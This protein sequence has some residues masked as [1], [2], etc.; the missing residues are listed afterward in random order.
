MAKKKF[1]GNSGMVQ[2]HSFASRLG[3]LIVTLIVIFLAIVAVLPMW[4]V[5]MSSVSDGHTLLSYKGF[6][7]I[8]IGKFTLNAYK[9]VLNNAS[10]IQGYM[11]TIIYV[12]GAVGLGLVLNVLGGYVLYR[13]TKLNTFLSLFVMFTM[14]FGGGMVATFMVM[15][16]LHLTGTRLV[17]ILQLA[18]NAMYIVVASNAFSGVPKETV[19][20]AILDGAGDLTIMFKVMLPQCM[21]LMSVTILNTF[22]GAWNSWVEASMP[23]YKK[24]MEEHPDAAQYMT[25]DVDG[26]KKFLAI[27][28]TFED[29]SMYDQWY[30]YAY[31]RDWLVKY[32]TQPDTFYDPMVDTEPKT[33][34]NAGQAFSGHYTLDTDG[35]T[36]DTTEYSD[37]VNGDS[38]VDDVVFPSGNVDPVY[39]T[40]WEWM[41]DIFAKALEAEG[42]T[43]G[44]GLSLYYPGY[45]GTGD[46]VSGFGGIGP[47]WYLDENGKCTFGAT[48]DGFKSYLECMSTW[49]KNGWIDQRFDQRSSDAFYQ[50]DN[51]TVRQGKV[52]AWLATPSELMSRIQTD[53]LETTKGAVVYTC[54]SPINDKYGSEETQLKKPTCFSSPELISSSIVVTDKAKDKDLKLL[55]EFLDYLYTEEGLL[56]A[57]GG[58]NQEQAA[59]AQDATYSA[60][61]VDYGYDPVQ[62][63]DGKTLMALT[64]KLY[65]DEGDIRNAM[66]L[67]RLWRLSAKNR[68]VSEDTE[69]YTHQRENWVKYE[70][71]GAIGA[72]VNGQL[73][74]DQAATMQKLTNRIGAEYMY[75]EVP[76]F[77]KGTYN[78]TTDWD[79]FVSDLNKR[80]YQSLVDTYNE[81]LN[82]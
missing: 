58:L 6:A 35:N 55:C 76:K 18:T 41:L 64:P 36:I 66:T 38:W 52:G 29:I 15:N 21:S 26:E 73:D 53:T 39:I 28:S 44:Y 81:A 5:L 62:G 2:N 30:G 12:A 60:Y 78:L 79:N 16:A 74:S 3:S 71:T 46:L 8:P 61:G 48:S 9:L 69:T 34:P 27:Y 54:A 45:V 67:G 32:G 50:I 20:S 37:T 7:I 80:D 70:A 75:I 14:M 22:I 82:K 40:D 56:L 42:I 19:E 23:N 47:T 77:I 13:K 17:I 10:V 49:Y 4:H 63:D 25:Q 68:Y 24:W 33:N 43:D 51:T 31:R 65:A 11:N 72:I 57:N 59:E 1:S